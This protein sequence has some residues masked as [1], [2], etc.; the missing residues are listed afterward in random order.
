MG[1]GCAIVG[2]EASGMQLGLGLC[3][4]G[5]GTEY[6]LNMSCWI[7]WMCSLCSQCCNFAGWK[8]CQLSCQGCMLIG[9]VGIGTVLPGQGLVVSWL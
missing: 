3:G 2:E 9:P 8:V 7:R 5:L 4:S 1:W 6:L